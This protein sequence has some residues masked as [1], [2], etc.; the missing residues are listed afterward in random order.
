MVAAEEFEPRV[1]S[2]VWNDGC[3]GGLS[4][5]GKNHILRREAEL[6]VFVPIVATA[7]S[8]SFCSMGTILLTYTIHKDLEPKPL[9]DQSTVEFTTGLMRDESGVRSQDGLCAGY[10]MVDEWD[11]CF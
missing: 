2:T 10:V 1:Q 4:M 5:V 6:A 3:F 9:I 8:L 11:T 7:V